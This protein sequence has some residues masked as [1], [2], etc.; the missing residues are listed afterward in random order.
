M[1]FLSFKN[2]MRLGMCMGLAFVSLKSTKIHCLFSNSKLSSPSK[3]QLLRHKLAKLKSS[4]ETSF[5][6]ACGKAYGFECP[7]VTLSAGRSC[8][9]SF[10]AATHSAFDHLGFFNSVREM[11]LLLKRCGEA[12][13]STRVIGDSYV[14]Y[15]FRY[16]TLDSKK[17]KVMKVIRL[18]GDTRLNLYKFS[19]ESE[20]KLSAMDKKL[21]L[22]VKEL[23]DKLGVEYSD[24]SVLLRIAKAGCE[25]T[26]PFYNNYKPKDSFGK[27]SLKE[28][29]EAIAR[30]R[31]GDEG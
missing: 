26:E 1:Q 8:S 3:V 5:K 6:K 21:M 4:L 28:S 17:E 31:V 2:A 16:F 7:H 12:E 18:I 9:A 22:S 29:I 30:L 25:V 10:E 20:G 13:C 24:P 27:E 23:A 19:I 11:W 14:V 15:Q